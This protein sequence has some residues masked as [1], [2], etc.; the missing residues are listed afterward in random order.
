MEFGTLFKDVPVTH[1]S[2]TKCRS[3]MGWDIVA[4]AS[5]LM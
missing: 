2:V 4:I 3:S 1:S 5:M